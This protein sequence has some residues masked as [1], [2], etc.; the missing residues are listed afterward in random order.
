[1]TTF[2][3][4]GAEVSKQR[5]K[6][7]LDATAMRQ[8]YEP[9]NYDSAWHRVSGSEEAREFINEISGYVLEIVA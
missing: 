4:N 6:Q 8:G 3:I 5:A 9:E 7:C 2:Y 1:M